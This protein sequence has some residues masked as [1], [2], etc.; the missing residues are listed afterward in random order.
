MWAGLVER[1]HAIHT[2]PEVVR[3]LLD[4]WHLTAITPRLDGL[5]DRLAAIN[6]RSRKAVARWRG[7]RRK[8]SVRNSRGCV[9]TAVRAGLADRPTGA[10]AMQEIVLVTRHARQPTAVCGR[11]RAGARAA[12]RSGLAVV[13]GTRWSTLWKLVEH[14]VIGQKAAVAAAHRDVERGSVAR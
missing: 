10:M 2:Q 4:A 3:V 7:R 6:A 11:I 5:D 1:P 14:D 8:A 9:I 13:A 12:V